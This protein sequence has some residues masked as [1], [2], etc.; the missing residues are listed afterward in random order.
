M[1]YAIAFHSNMEGGGCGR[2]LNSTITIRKDD[3][4]REPHWENNFFIYSS[5]WW[6]VEFPKNGTKT[7][8]TGYAIDIK[9]I[10]KCPSTGWN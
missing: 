8:L 3:R 1:H 7:S 6:R 10:I 5:E 4:L 9:C 2:E